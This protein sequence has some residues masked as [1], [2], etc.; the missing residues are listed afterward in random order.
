MTTI[1]A[2]ATGERQERRAIG[3]SAVL[4]A[5]AVWSVASVLGKAADVPGLVLGFWRMWLG[6]VFMTFA[7]LL[8]GRIPSFA[9]IRRAFP[10]GVLFG[11]NICAFFQSL[12]YLSIAIAL[13]I[14]AL[15]PVVALPFAVLFMGERLTRWKVLCALGAVAGVVGAVLAAKSDDDTPNSAQGYA[16]AVVALVVWVTY[17]LM[18]KRARDT[19]ETVRLMWVMQFGGAVTVS[20][21]A[22]VLRPD[23]GQLHGTGWWW[24]LLLTVFPGMLGHGLFVWAQPRVDSSVS[25]VL[26]QGEPVGA[27]FFAWLFLH[28]QVTVAQTLWMGM[29]LASLCLLAYQESRERHDESSLIAQPPA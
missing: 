28:E 1:A 9:D 18:N 13:I 26:I 3:I 16:W 6:T 24:L 10:T 11:L 29:V 14:A 12:Q 15:T 5:T 21:L 7:V 22:L 17:L 2:G 25:S 8:T 19:V 4:G 23:L 20:L 27:T